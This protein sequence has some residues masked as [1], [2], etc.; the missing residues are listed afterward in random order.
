MT[1]AT[2]G[3]VP[4]DL[5][6]RLAAAVASGLR[7]RLDRAAVNQWDADAR[8]AHPGVVLSA[9]QFATHLARHLTAE[10]LDAP[11]AWFPAD[12][13][14]AA[15]CLASDAKA[16]AQLDR[17]LR[18]GKRSDEAAQRARERLLVGPAPRLAEY[19][20]RAPL[21]AWVGLV[22]KR[23]AIDVQREEPT[24]PGATPL[25]L[26]AALQ[27]SPELHFLKADGVRRVSNALR[28][29][30]GQLDDRDRL[31]L[32]RHYLEGVSHAQLAS[33]LGAA[34]STVAV[35]IEKARQRLLARTREQ[36]D[37]LRPRELDSLL[38]VVGSHL[39][40]SFSELVA[41]GSTQDD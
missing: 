20:G 4:A 27:S 37:G 41:S 33:Q 25:S 24:A 7:A 29:A 19:A 10:V 3:P 5:H 38:A 16:L 21:K 14:L 35:W 13:F 17:W 34:R 31:L 39:D 23:I 22:V 30:L 40:L 15:A 6:Q 36:I 2:L 26:V 8:S 18:Q 12:L 1:R 28:D 9:D 32:R 11:R